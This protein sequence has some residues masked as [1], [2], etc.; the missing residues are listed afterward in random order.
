MNH[1]A[2][3]IPFILQVIRSRFPLC[4]YYILYIYCSLSS[5]TQLKVLELSFNNFSDNL[6]S[7]ITNITSLSHLHLSS[8][9]LVDLPDR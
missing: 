9:Q 1:L 2:A 4:I 3:Y 7:V 8:C 5:L 6:P